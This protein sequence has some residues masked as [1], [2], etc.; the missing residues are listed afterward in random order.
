[1]GEKFRP[2]LHAPPPLRGSYASRA[3]FAV[4]LS[5][6]LFLCVGAVAQNRA[7]N[8]WRDAPEMAA[9]RRPTELWITPSKF[10]PVALDH[11]AMRSALARARKESD[12]NGAPAEIE[13]P[14]PD[15][16]TQKFAILESPVM[17]PELAAQFP[18]IKTYVGHGLDDRAATAR[19][20][21]T[22]AGFHAQVLSPRGAVYIDPHTRDATVYASYYKR[23]Y[24]KDADDFRCLGPEPAPNVAN[25][26]G[27]ALARSSGGNLRTYRLAVAA[28]A[29]YTAFHGGTV[30]L[31]LAAVVTAVN[32][33][34]GVYETEMAI[35][36]VLV[37]NNNLLIYTNANSDPYTDGNSSSLLVQNQSTLDGIIGSANY[38]IGHV[39]STAGG[40]LAQLG[41]VCVSGSKAR[42]E[43]GTSAPIG[44]PY[45]IDYVAHEMGHQF[46]AN[47]TFNSTLGSCSGNRNAS[48]AYEP[49]SGSTIMAYAGI[50][51]TDNLQPHSDPYFHAG[52]FDEIVVFSTAGS[53]SMCP[54]LSNTSNSFPTV[55]AGTNYT[56][57]IGTP[58]T[59][60]AS[61]S[62]SNG[63]VLTFCWEE[64]DLGVSTTLTAAD[65]GASPL[66]RSFN[67]TT[68]ASRTFPQLASILNN[69]ASLGEKLPTTNRAMKFRV[70]A[71]D[72]RAGGG[73][74]NT[75]DTTVTST[76]A[77]GP[78]LITSHNGGGTF[79]GPTTVTWN[80][81]GTAGSPVNAAN[82]KI[83]LSTN[84][85]VDFPIVLLAST[86]N[87]GSESVPLPDIFA[88]NGR[89]KIEA[90][91]NIFFDVN[92]TNFTIV[93][94][95]PTPLLALL[96]TSLASEGCYSNN[97]ID[98]NEPVTVRF[99][100]Q[101]NGSGSTSNLVATLLSTNGVTALS[102]AQAYGVIAGNG[103]A[104]TQAFSFAVT[105]S[106]G[107]QFTAAL[108]LQDGTNDFGTVSKAFTLGAATLFTKSFTNGSTIS[109]DDNANATPFPST[110]IVSG[111]SGTVTKA[112]ITLRE[113]THSYPSDVDAL[114]VAPAGTA[115]AMFMSDGGDGSRVRNIT[116]TFD[117]AAAIALPENAELTSGVFRPAD[118][119]PGES[120]TAPA[121]AGPYVSALSAFNGVNP[122]GAWSLYIADDAGMD[123]GD[124]GL[125]WSLTLTTALPNCGSCAS[126]P[127]ITSITRSSG[128]ATLRWSAVS[129]VAYRV[130]FKTNLSSSAW[131]DLPG[132]VTATN[133]SATKSDTNAASQRFYRVQVVP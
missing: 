76:I 71:R 2:M 124:V 57:P 36:L 12:A 109:I 66:F 115:S 4:A 108:K 16:T 25:A 114:L 65:N 34:N 107:G 53:G 62:D 105:G 31:G 41:V 112:V 101:N 27:G 68:N 11:A 56:I 13:L 7:A 82:V 63:D 92:N 102:T 37:A 111:M 113:L 3:G 46:G 64:R 132:D 45:Y 85:G 133:L 33:V 50:C 99:V 39:F 131:F 118:Y 9:G 125:G 40:G 58:F 93:P 54:V 35:R 117:D 83:S 89:I 104:A 90:V 128:V 127:V 130:Q 26:A 61:G 29:E 18:E 30:P 79:S 78:F 73:G 119:D 121:P 100:L 122:N 123:S 10:R 70:T 6:L 5:C 59:L 24:R 1:M 116:L 80:P 60:T 88:S 32:R 96:T 77:A 103:G 97:A 42:G 69:T 55:S 23:D 44:D 19:L 75:A 84:G 47:H 49:G 87:D 91:G 22:P 17:A 20:D 98:P 95:T 72:N 120:F 52:S 94:F 43:T 21:I 126:S 38:D 28:T 86:A 8:P 74:V 14:M 15:G 129:N 81:A 48:T 110:I 51:S 67:P 106:C